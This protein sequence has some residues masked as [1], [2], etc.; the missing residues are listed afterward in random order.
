MLISYGVFCNVDDVHLHLL[1]NGIASL[2]LP[3][4]YQ[5]KVQ[6]L[7]TVLSLDAAWSHLWNEKLKNN[8][9][10]K[11]PSR[12]IC[13]NLV[14]E[15][16]DDS[17]EK[18]DTY[19][20][21]Y[22]V[23]NECRFSGMFIRYAAMLVGKS[24]RCMFL[25]HIRVQ[26]SAV[27]VMLYNATLEKATSFVKSLIEDF[28]ELADKLALVEVELG[29]LLQLVR[30]LIDVKRALKPGVDLK[31]LYKSF[32]KPTKKFRKS[33]KEEFENFCAV[34][35]GDW[36]DETA[37]GGQGKIVKL[38]EFD[39]DD[40][41]ENVADL[42]VQVESFRNNMNFVFQRLFIRVMSPE[43]WRSLFESPIIIRPELSQ[44]IETGEVRKR[45]YAPVEE[46]SLNF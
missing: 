38:V 23:V 4:E 9:S 15:G 5:H 39:A 13:E 45:E 22:K 12:E 31:K 26:L 14:P 10:L 21:V 11:P 41:D 8:E 6:L 32:K 27:E 19:H 36:F 37:D 44:T 17:K 24:L 28:G 33:I 34:K 18:I 30:H 29:L 20:V 43:I 40:K 16:T 1:E 7:E 3:A 42:L 2:E 46:I 25:R 35:M